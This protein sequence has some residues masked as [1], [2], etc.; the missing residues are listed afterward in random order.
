MKSIPKDK[1]QLAYKLLVLLLSF[2]ITRCFNY[3]L[4]VETL[5]SISEDKDQLALERELKL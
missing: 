5:K 2:C 1:G 3:E 4:H